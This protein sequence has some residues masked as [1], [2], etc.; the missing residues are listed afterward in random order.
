MRIKTIVPDV[1]TI[2]GKQTSL[3]RSNLIRLIPN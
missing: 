1:A 3:A 2:C